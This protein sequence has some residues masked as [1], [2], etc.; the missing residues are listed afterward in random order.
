LSEPYWV[1]SNNTAEQGLLDRTGSAESFASLSKGSLGNSQPQLKSG[2]VGLWAA[3]ARACEFRPGTGSDLRTVIGERGA[4]AGRNSC[5][6]KEKKQIGN[7]EWEMKAA[8]ADGSARWE[9]TVRLSLSKNK[10]K[11][12]GQRGT[13]I[14]VKC[15]WRGVCASQSAELWAQSSVS[16]SPYRQKAEIEYQ[17]QGRRRARFGIRFLKGIRDD[18]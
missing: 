3:D 17:A 15:T 8:C 12:S 2:F 10:L 5:A 7:A 13:Q 11:W 6:F 16:V 18:L 1:K 4:R 9:S 14:Y